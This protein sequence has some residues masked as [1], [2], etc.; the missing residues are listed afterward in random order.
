MP[1]VTYSPFVFYVA[2][3]VFWLIAVCSTVWF[4][5]WFVKR[6]VI[7]AEAIAEQRASL[8]E[9]QAGTASEVAVATTA[10]TDMVMATAW[11]VILLV[12]V[13]ISS[14]TLKNHLLM[15]RAEPQ[16]AAVER[17]EQELKDLEPVDHEAINEAREETVE[18]AKE[19]YDDYRKRQQEKARESSAEYFESL[20]KNNPQ[21]KQKQE[22]TEQK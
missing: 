15:N 20:K 8:D 7:R 17:E 10:V 5:S 2:N 3:A 21:V 19:E 18:K 16:N 13:I 22:S 4:V 9:R 6:L 1:E 14:W 11:R 12:L